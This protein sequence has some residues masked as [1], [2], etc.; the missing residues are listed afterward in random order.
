MHGLSPRLRTGR[1][2]E[3]P[4]T[5][6]NITAKGMS[7]L[8]ESRACRVEESRTQLALAGA[9]ADTI[10][11]LRNAGWSIRNSLDVSL[12]FHD[13]QRYIA[14]SRGEFSVAKQRM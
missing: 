1:P 6:V 11:R 5:T 2:T 12:S 8:V 13:Y 9:G 14:A 7:N 10:S 4:H 3:M